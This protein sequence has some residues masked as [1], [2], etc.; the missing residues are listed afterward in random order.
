[1]TRIPKPANLRPVFM[2]LLLLCGTTQAPAVVASSP[3]VEIAFDASAPYYEPSLAVVPTGTA[4]R[5]INGTASPHSVRHDSCVADEACAFQSIA[6]PP[7]SSFLVAPLPPGRY[8][9]HCELHP[10]MRGTLIVTESRGDHEG[11]RRS[12]PR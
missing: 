1:M 9:Y 8:S 3:A 6:I 2:T 11:E 4:V 12:L 7:D 5:W 10:I